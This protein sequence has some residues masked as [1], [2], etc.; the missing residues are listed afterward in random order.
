MARTWHYHIYGLDLV[1]DFEIKGLS[2]RQDHGDRA[3]TVAMNHAWSL[4]DIC[5]QSF[6][7]RVA[8]ESPPE[9]LQRA[10]L[11]INGTGYFF[12]YRYRH[13]AVVYFLNA[14]MNRLEII[15]DNAIPENSIN[16]LMHPILAWVARLK[17]TTCLHANVMEKNGEAIA[18][19]GDKGAGKS[20]S[21]AVLLGAGY[22]M[23]AD[24][25]CALQESGEHFH[26]LPGQPRPKV[27]ANSV[28][29]LFPSGV[30]TEPFLQMERASAS[31]KVYVAHASCN[32]PV[33]L[34]G[35][36]IIAGRDARLSQPVA[37]LC[38]RI[39]ALTW[40]GQ[41]VIFNQGVD[42]AIRRNDF[43]VLSRLTSKVP[44]RLLYNPDSIAVLRSTLAACVE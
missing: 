16:L 23:V 4:R 17:G 13:R 39:T 8:L 1:S 44:V 30:V 28:A 19:L 18:I 24:D 20:T 42:L 37:D 43:L 33:R 21:C 14:A 11:G 34:K 32:E 6:E 29:A 36:Y 35:L 15:N 12:I 5:E 26:A 41:H 3:I 10:E 2:A 27:M 40:L 22:R 7:R 9:G 38:S 31:D 25:V